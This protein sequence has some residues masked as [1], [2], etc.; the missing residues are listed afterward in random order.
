MNRTHIH[1]AP[2]LPKESGVISG[3]SSE[4]SPESLCYFTLVVSGMRSG[5]QVYIYIDLVK[6]L[7]GL[8]EKSVSDLMTIRLF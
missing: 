7:A 2:G 3:M 6:A 4:E 8:L 5:A 1:F